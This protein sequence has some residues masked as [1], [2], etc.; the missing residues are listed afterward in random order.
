MSRSSKLTECKILLL[1]FLFSHNEASDANI[2]IIANFVYHNLRI[3]CELLV[4]MYKC[5]YQKHP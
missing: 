1:A 4:K 3:C 2:G 5:K